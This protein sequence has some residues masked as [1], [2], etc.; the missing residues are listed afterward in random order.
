MVH[1]RSPALNTLSGRTSSW[2]RS[3]RLMGRLSTQARK[4]VSARIEDFQFNLDRMP[5]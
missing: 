2:D 1:Q 5:A 4:L 3:H